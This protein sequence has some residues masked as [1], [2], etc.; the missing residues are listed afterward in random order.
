M[1]AQK[2]KSNWKLSLL[3]WLIFLFASSKFIYWI[4]T[5][6]NLLPDYYLYTDSDNP[7]MVNWTW[8]FFPLDMSVCASAYAAL[9]LKRNNWEVWRP[10]AFISLILISV[11]GLMPISFWILSGFFNW[12]WWLGQLAFLFVPFFF[13][14]GLF[15]SFYKEK[16]K[17]NDDMYFNY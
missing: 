2:I 5:I 15:N 7:I 11:S 9:L 14:P 12:I 10:I 3:S 16:D 4:I 1:N 6:F 13:L 17:S 8:S